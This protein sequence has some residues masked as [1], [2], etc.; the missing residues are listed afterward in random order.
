MPLIYS[1]V[2]FHNFDFN[3]DWPAIACCVRYEVASW[4]LLSVI[5][6]AGYTV[7]VDRPLHCNRCVLCPV[8]I[9]QNVSTFSYQDGEAVR[10]VCRPSRCRSTSEQLRDKT[11]RLR[12]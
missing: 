10:L 3:R 4:T 1:L 11:T 9:S 5:A 7:D 6:V 12:V 8:T 2:T